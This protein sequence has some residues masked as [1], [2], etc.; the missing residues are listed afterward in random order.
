M[1]VFEGAVSGNL[2]EV[3]SQNAMRVELF[4]ASAAIALPQFSEPSTPSGPLTFGLNDA[5]VVP[6]RVDRFGSVASALHQSMFVES[7]ESTVVNAQRWLV[8]NTTM[9]ATQSSVAGLTI[10]SGNIVTAST[11]YMIQSAR[12]FAKS[13]RGLLQFKARARL[14]I[15][16]NSVMEIGFGDAATFNGANTAG[17]Y[18]QVTAG[19]VVIP[20]VT[21][22]GT[23]ITGTSVAG[24]STT[25]YY[26]LDVLMDD[27]EAVFVIQ[28]TE[29][30][31][32]VSRQTVRLPLLQQRLWSA[33]QLPIQMRLYNTATPPATAPNL[34][35]TDVYVSLIDANQNRD[36]ATIQSSIEKG[37]SSHPFSGAQLSAWTNNAEPAN[38]TLSNTTAGYTTL[39]GKFQFAAPVGAA[40]DFCLFGFQVPTPANF[41][42]TGVNINAWNLGA[43]VATTPTLLTWGLAVGSTAVSLST[44]TVMRRGLG[45]MSFPIGAVIGAT[46]DREIGRQFITPILCPAGRFVQ[47]IL[48]I[49]VGTATASQVIAGMV[50]F[51]GYFE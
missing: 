13:Q 45:S 30:H 31:A 19:G 20:V 3:G 5:S 4:G 32:I 41:Y 37:V 50:N 27:D 38:A 11:G 44:A 26:T 40:T 48:R 9:A 14:N 25:A 22:N 36:F 49:P 17:A 7:F 24:L 23:D 6:V 47:V 42:I 46:A 16:A 33:T 18:W 43:A 8:T 29:T 2:A 39:G 28:N 34:I 10:N 15:A 1:A 12:R 51:D 35:V 21:F